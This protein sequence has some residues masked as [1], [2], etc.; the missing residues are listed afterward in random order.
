MAGGWKAEYEGDGAQPGKQGAA[1]S[2][3][4]RGLH[5]GDR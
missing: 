2:V 3:E 1:N 4:V 5:N